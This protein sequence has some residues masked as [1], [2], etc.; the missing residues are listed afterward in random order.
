MSTT[1]DTL[2]FKAGEEVNLIGIVGKYTLLRNITTALYLN[3]KT[4][5]QVGTGPTAAFKDKAGDTI[6]FSI[7]RLE[8]VM[9][10]LE[11]L[12]LT[13]DETYGIYGI[14]L[15]KHELTTFEEAEK[16]AIACVKEGK[17]AFI[18]RLIAEVVTQAPPT[19]TKLSY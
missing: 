4:Y 10:E 16:T 9:T 3:S 17:P 19:E 13:T 7:N 11:K 1:S 6:F 8:K 12:R 14:G 18:Y 15:R 2:A 5:L